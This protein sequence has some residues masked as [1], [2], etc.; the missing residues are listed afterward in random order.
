[1][2]HLKHIRMGNQSFLDA[3]K[4]QFVI[5]KYFYIFI[6]CIKDQFIFLVFFKVIFLITECIKVQFSNLVL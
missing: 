1:M 4:G 3:L 6:R 2:K 5:F